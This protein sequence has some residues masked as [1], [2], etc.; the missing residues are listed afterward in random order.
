MHKLEMGKKI[1]GFILF[2]ALN[3]NF[4]KN[5]FEKIKKNTNE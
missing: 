2:W 5:Q 4:L 3:V 1:C